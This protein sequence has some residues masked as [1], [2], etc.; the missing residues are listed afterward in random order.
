[1]HIGIFN[2]E[3][4]WVLFNNFEWHHDIKLVCGS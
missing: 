4:G 3:L 2:S 1:M